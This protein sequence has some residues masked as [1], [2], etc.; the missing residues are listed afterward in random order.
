MRLAKLSPTPSTPRPTCTPHIYTQSTWAS[1]HEQGMQKTAGEVTS[2]HKQ[3]NPFTPVQHRNIPFSLRAG[4]TALQNN[5]DKSWK[6][7][8]EGKK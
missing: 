3:P 1:A 6:Q 7:I 8:V 5:M 2:G 4:V